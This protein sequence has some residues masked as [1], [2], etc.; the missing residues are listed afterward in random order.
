LSS[1]ID[2]FQPFRPRPDGEEAWLQLWD[3]ATRWWVAP[4]QGRRELVTAKEQLLVGLID[5]LRGRFE[6]RQMELVLGDA[7]LRAVLESIRLR[8]PEAH[9]DARVELRDV[10][11]DGWRFETLSIAAD[12]VTIESFPSPEFTASGITVIGSA[13]IGPLVARLDERATEWHLGVDGEGRV[14]VR[15]RRRGLSLRMTVEPVVDHDALKVQLVALRWGKMRL[16]PP[17]WMRL[18]RR[19]PL[20]PLPLGMSIVE[21]RRRGRGVEFRLAV[22]SV[23]RNIDAALVREAILRRLPIPLG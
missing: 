3:E 11:G 4:V 5:G 21:A 8:R 16:S 23:S 18:T 17:R 19:F 14:E 2:P 1:P 9:Y 13:A 22:A 12:S 20:A 6:G 10:E 15:R 7:R